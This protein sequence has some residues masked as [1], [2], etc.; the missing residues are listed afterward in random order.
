M[1]R[2]TNNSLA[3]GETPMILAL[4]LP[5][6]ALNSIASEGTPSGQK[7]PVFLLE[8]RGSINPGSAAYITESIRKAEQEKAQAIILKLDTPG[9][10]LSST[11]D[12]IQSISASSVPFITFVSPSGASATSAGA[13]IAI[14]SHLA[15]M[16]P[17]TNIGA[18][19]PVGPQGEDVKGAMGDKVTNDTA[20]LARSQAELRGRKKE[21]AELIVTKSKSYSPEEARKEGAI[22][23]VAGDLDA[24]LTQLQG[25]KIKLDNPVREVTLETKGITA[26][27]VTFL[28]MNTKQYFL[29]LIAH[30]N[31]STMLLAIGGVAIY[32][33]VSAGFSLLV[34]GI[35]GLFCIL[36]AFV[37]LQMLPINIGGVLLFV[38]GFGLLAAEFFVTSYGLLTVAALIS[39]F[40]G[41]LFLIDPSVGKELHVS[42]TLLSSIVF[43]IGFVAFF[44]GYLFSREKRGL[45]NGI[46]DQVVGQTAKVLEVWAG[47]L[48]GRALVNG[49]L[50]NFVAKETLRSGEE[51]KVHAVK[52]VHIHL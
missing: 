4:L 42:L 52:G 7:G 6:I 27:S 29:H 18:A 20:A 1:G 24:L 48:E 19:H 39:I 8:V 23:L 46:G 50:W 10:L 45:K 38:L 36:L 40:V 26:S 12:I 5:L 13:L 41:G 25:R 43:G 33:E 11:R 51:R 9:G 31:I 44:F 34:P 22:D 49:E 16:A 15:A 21:T 47:G 30:P 28:E 32:A 17:G 2:F 3:L 35:F 14:S 37:S